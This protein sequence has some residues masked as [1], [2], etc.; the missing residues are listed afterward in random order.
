VSFGSISD[1]RV[2][3][4]DWPGEIVL[5]CETGSCYQWRPD[6]HYKVHNARSILGDYLQIGDQV[7]SR[8][9]VGK[10]DQLAYYCGLLEIFA[11]GRHRP[12]SLASLAVS[13]A[14]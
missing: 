10:E 4:S 14:D 9:N 12:S 8:F 11:K 2:R 3:R 6:A 7:W 1:F 5:M 13:L